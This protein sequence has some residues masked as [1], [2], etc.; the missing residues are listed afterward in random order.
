MPT[1]AGDVSI[2][3]RIKWQELDPQ[4]VRATLSNAGN[5]ISAVLTFD[6]SGALLNFTSNDR[7]RTTDGKTYGRI[8]WSTPVTAWQTHNGRKLP[9][10]EARWQLPTASWPMGASRLPTPR[11]TWPAAEATTAPIG[12]TMSLY[13]FQLA[14]HLDQRWETVLKASRSA[15]SLPEA[16]SRSRC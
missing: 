2:D 14:G 12:T 8:R 15:T 6:A 3:P 10:A 7:S 5:T 4:T 13:T 1:R 16:G 11:I 9:A